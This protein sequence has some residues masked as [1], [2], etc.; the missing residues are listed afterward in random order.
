M[1]RRDFINC[2]RGWMKGVKK[3]RGIGSLNIGRAN[4]ISLGSL[5]RGSGFETLRRTISVAKRVQ[6]FSLL[7]NGI[8]VIASRT[9]PFPEDWSPQTTSCGR[10]DPFK[11]TLSKRINN[12]KDLPL[13]I[14]LKRVKR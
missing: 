2:L 9:E 11:S 8:S 4:V 13:L 1:F 10:D 7:G 6:R 12:V 3:R 14:T 5:S